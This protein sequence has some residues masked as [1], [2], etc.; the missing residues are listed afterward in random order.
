[1]D[2]KRL[3][4][5]MVKT[6]LVPR[7]I[8]DPRVLKAMAEVPRHLFVESSRQ[9]LAYEDMALPTADGQTISQPY[10]VA[11]MTE[12]LELSGTEKVLEIGTG[13]GYQAAILAELSR[14]VYTIERYDDLTE[15]AAG[16]FR[17]LTYTTIFLKTG[18]GTLGWPEEAPFDRIMVTAGAPDP[19]QP[20]IDQ[21]A[22]GG[23]LVIPVGD[24]NFQQLLR[25]R[26]N[27]DGLT[28]ELHTPCMFV[29]LIGRFGWDAG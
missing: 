11:V 2:Y 21:L 25:I 27:S 18:D 17:D 16:R 10:M 20:L 8:R 28:R 12:L 3:R 1:M 24:R 4:E 14:A 7:G 29:P 9:Q 19:P 22:P 26:K 23:I 13:S 6:Q 15:Q 5:A